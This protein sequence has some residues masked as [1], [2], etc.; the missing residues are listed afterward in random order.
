MCEYLDYEVKKL[1]RTRIMN[2]SLGDLQVGQ[3]RYLTESEMAEINHSIK[4]SGKT[5]ERSIDTNKKVIY[6]QK[7]NPGSTKGQNKPRRTQNH[8]STNSTRTDAFGR[9]IKP[10]SNHATNNKPKRVKR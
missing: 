5:E 2:V 3:W 4:D 7:S 8:T 10:K 1:K 9:P 6:K